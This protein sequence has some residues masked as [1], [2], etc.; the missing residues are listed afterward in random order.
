MSD[1]LVPLLL[2]LFPLAYSP[3]PG[4][5]FFAALGAR[6]GLPAAVSA[7]AGYH[8]A[9]VIVTVLI[10]LGFATVVPNSGMFAQVMRFAGAGYVAWLGWR[11]MSA[12]A[13]AKDQAGRLA[14]FWSGVLLLAL[15]PKAYV[16]IGLMFSQFLQSGTGVVAISVVFTLNNLLAF[17]LWTLLGDQLTRLF[18]GPQ[19]GRRLNLVFGVMLIIVALWMAWG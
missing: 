1:S 14:G 11:F 12:E 16:I 8:L 6:A 15:N 2:F 9:T 17:V 4:N 18:R 7:L 10:G 13:G 5:M 3:G 19:T